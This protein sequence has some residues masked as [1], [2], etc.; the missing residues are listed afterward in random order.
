MNIPQDNQAIVTITKDQLAKLPAA[1]FS[2]SIKLIDRPEDVDQAIADLKASQIIGFDTE[3]R[4]TF[5]KGHLHNVSL[6]QL[7]TPTTCYLFR[8]NHI[9]LVQGL[10]DILQDKELLKVGLSIHDDFHSLRRIAPIEPSGFIDLQQYVKKYKIADNSLSRIY[11]ILFGERISKGQR[12]TNWEAEILSPA[13]QTYAALDAMACI[14]IYN[15]LCSGAFY[16]YT[17]SYL[18]FPDQEQPSIPNPNN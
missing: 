3:T 2:G 15:H 7:A 13:Q 11:G 14:K 17:S 10:I 1:S 18:V 9:G 4:P 6:M 5:K 16:P 12:L 8:L